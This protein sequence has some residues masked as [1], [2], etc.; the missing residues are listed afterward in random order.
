MTYDRPR[1]NKTKAGPVKGEKAFPD[2]GCLPFDLTGPAFVLSY[3]GRLPQMFADDAAEGFF[4]YGHAVNEF[5]V[6]NEED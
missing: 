2:R 5:T 4:V 3:K 1:E 6:R